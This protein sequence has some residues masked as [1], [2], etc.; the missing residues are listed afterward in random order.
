MRVQQRGQSLFPEEVA[1]RTAAG[2][3]E[4]VSEAG[5]DAEAQ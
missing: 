2:R 5:R 1:V 3:Q 4:L